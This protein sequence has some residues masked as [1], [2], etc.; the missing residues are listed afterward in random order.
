MRLVIEGLKLQGCNPDF[1]DGRD[2]LLAADIAL[3]GGADQCLI[4]EVFAK[5]G[6]GVAASRGD[7]AVFNDQVE[8][9]TVPDASDPS[10]AN[11]TTLSADTFNTS[12]YKIYPNP[13]TNTITIT[14][15]RNLGDVKLQ[16][17][18]INGRMVLT[19]STT[20]SRNVDL[21]ISGL[22]SGLY[23]LKIVGAYNS[24]NHKIIKE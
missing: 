21:D 2:G 9:F 18:D 12:D 24:T 5:R 17:V 7:L 4:W 10:L 15:N 22:Q 20:L 14:S 3:T 13:A 23:V 1:I 16:L 11:C 8:D 6:L 19:K